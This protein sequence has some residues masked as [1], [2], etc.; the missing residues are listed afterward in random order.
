MAF[1]TRLELR[2]LGSVVEHETPNRAAAAA[3]TGGS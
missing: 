1:T 2:D 3:E